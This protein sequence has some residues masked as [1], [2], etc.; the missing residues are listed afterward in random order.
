MAGP[1]TR[2]ANERQLRHGQA[3]IEAMMGTSK[4]RYLV[5]VDAAAILDAVAAAAAACSFETQ[6]EAEVRSDPQQVHASESASA[7]KQREY[8][9]RC[10]KQDVIDSAATPSTGCN[11]P[12]M[13]LTELRQYARGHTAGARADGVVAH[14]LGVAA[15]VVSQT[16]RSQNR[17][18]SDSSCS[19]LLRRGK[20]HQANGIELQLDDGRQTGT[21]CR[22]IAC[23]T[24]SETSAHL[25]DVLALA[26]PAAAEASRARACKRATN[27]R[28]QIIKRQPRKTQCQTS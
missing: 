3:Q 12:E 21:R 4:T 25:V 13:Q 16:L 2:A 10:E 9:K 1:L 28:G 6:H 14:S 7:S 15:A 22:E 26:V 24:E 20:T 27:E 19:R 8:A 5:D 18:I 17:S 11:M 23:V